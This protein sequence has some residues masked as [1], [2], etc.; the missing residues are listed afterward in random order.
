MDF[1]IWD[2]FK[3]KLKH[4]DTYCIAEQHYVGPKYFLW[5]NC[6][7]MCTFLG[8]PSRQ[9]SKIDIK[10]QIYIIGKIWSLDFDGWGRFKS[11][12]EHQDIYS[13]IEQLFVRPTIRYNF[14]GKFYIWILTFDI[15]LN[16][17]SNTK[18][19]IA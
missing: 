10:N 1:D 14:T 16:Q 18:T 5:I 7:N 3:S 19:T 2:N 9:M 11:K 6:C 8:V 15:V 4:Q 12:L 17:N 13:T